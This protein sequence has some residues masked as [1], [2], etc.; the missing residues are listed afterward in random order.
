[1]CVL[2]QKKEKRNHVWYHCKDVCFWYVSHDAWEPQNNVCI[3][4]KQ[5]LRE[6]WGPHT[7]PLC[8]WVKTTAPNIEIGNS[9]AILQLKWNIQRTNNS[10]WLCQAGKGFWTQQAGTELDTRIRCN[11]TFIH[12]LSA[13]STKSANSEKR[14]SPNLTHQSAGEQW[15][16]G[17]QESVKGKSS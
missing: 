12:N 6:I 14:T 16:K 17:N 10:A 1:M 9:Q 11:K 3:K 4:A 15:M 5:R 13:M 7:K 8:C 2:P